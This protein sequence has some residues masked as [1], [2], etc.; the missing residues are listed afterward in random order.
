MF[1]S[2]KPR[3]SSS[4]VVDASMHAGRTL[5]D[6]LRSLVTRYGADAVR[7]AAKKATAKKRGRRPERDWPLLRPWL[8]QDVEDWLAERDPFAARSNYLIAKEYAAKHPGHNPIA[9]AERIERKLR[10]KRRWMLFAVALG[11]TDKG[12]PISVYL[13]ACEGLIEEGGSRD[14]SFLLD[15]PRGVLARYEERFGNDATA[16]SLDEMEEAL[17]Q[18]LP[19]L[20]GGVLGGLFGLGNLGS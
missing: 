8:D 18:P 1:G 9:T 13:K 11:R 4:S 2:S 5:D 12:W 10:E 15:R 16:L 14:W 20:G 19:T 3:S 6:E 7:E 17:R